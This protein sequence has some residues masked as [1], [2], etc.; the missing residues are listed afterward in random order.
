MN[1]YLVLKRT[2]IPQCLMNSPLFP[3]ITV[4]AF[5]WENPVYVRG[6]E[7]AIKRMPVLDQGQSDTCATF[8]STAA[9]GHS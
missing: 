5:T 3:R 9:M 7:Q 4:P 1:S 6:R 2:H 8:S